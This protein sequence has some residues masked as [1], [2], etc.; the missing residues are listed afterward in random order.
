MT[1]KIETSTLQLNPYRLQCPIKFYNS[2]NVDQRIYNCKM[3]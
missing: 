1:L 2:Q 3:C